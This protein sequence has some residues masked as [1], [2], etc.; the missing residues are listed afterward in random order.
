MRD[1]YIEQRFSRYFVFGQ[2]ETGNTCDISDGHD[3]TL[4]TVSNE[5][6]EKLIRNR[7]DVVDMIILLS[8]SLYEISPDKFVQIWYEKQDN[9][10]LDHEW[11]RGDK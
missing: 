1:N 9:I 4:A 2:D 3:M 8:Q 10:L 6:A 5:H 7:D 11:V